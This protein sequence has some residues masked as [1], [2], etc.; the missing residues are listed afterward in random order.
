[1][2]IA[3]P[4][5]AVFAATMIALGILALITGHFTSPWT[6]MPSGVPA[7]A[8]LVYLCAFISLASGITLLWHRTAL[9]A[10][11]ALLTCLPMDRVPDLLGPDG[12]RLGSG[13]FL[14]RSSLLHGGQALAPAIPAISRKHGPVRVD[15]PAEYRQSAPQ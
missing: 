11:R 1:M 3:S 10:S 2:R 7:R 5:H 8:V 9:A 14:R 15:A 4:G 13:R 12:R 6:G